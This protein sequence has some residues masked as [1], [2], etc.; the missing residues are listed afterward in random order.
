MDIFRYDGPL[1]RALTRAANMMIVSVLYLLSCLPMITLLPASAA[2][3]TVTVEVIRH[4]GEG[5]VKAYFKAFKEELKPGIVLSLLTIASACLLIVCLHFGYQMAHHWW[6]L[7][8]F[9]IGMLL[10][11][12]W[13]GMALHGPAVLAR[14]AVDLGNRLRLMLYFPMKHP[15]KTLLLLLLLALIVFFCDF[16][17][18]F[19]LIA[20][21]LFTDFACAAME[22]AIARFAKERGLEDRKEPEAVEIQEQPEVGALEQAKALE[23]EERGVKD[24]TA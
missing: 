6:G 8:Y 10:A 2:L 1:V 19:I 5:V 11:L 4:S 21:G 15:F 7:V 23:E 3:Y 16:F 9:S 18:L 24:G 13:A 17:P 20:P 14:F 12:L 22:P